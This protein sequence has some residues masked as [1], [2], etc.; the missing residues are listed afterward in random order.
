MQRRPVVYAASIY[1]ERRQKRENQG[2]LRCYQTGREQSRNGISRKGQARERM[3]GG[4]LSGNWCWRQGGGKS[5]G[6]EN[7]EGAHVN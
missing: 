1:L 6:T 4:G 2:S 7:K 3:R 5:E